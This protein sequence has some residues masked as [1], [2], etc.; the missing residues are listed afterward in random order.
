MHKN[1]T[2]CNKTQ[3]KLC[4]NKHGASKIIDTFATYHGPSTLCPPGQAHTTEDQPH[5]S[6][7]TCG[8]LEAGDTLF[9][10]AVWREDDHLAGHWHDHD[11]CD[12]R[13]RSHWGWI[14]MGGMSGS[15]VSPVTIPTHLRKE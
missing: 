15:L 5:D 10:P 4:V 3:S 7:H 11:S 6:Y 1:A 8:S 9:S 14:V 13:S 12:R 2:K